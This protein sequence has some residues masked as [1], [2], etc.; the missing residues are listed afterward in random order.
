MD[1][2]Q[3]RAVK[4]IY[5]FHYKGTQYEDVPIL[6][7]LDDLEAR[8]IRHHLSVMYRQSR[9]YSNIHTF[10]PSVDLRSQ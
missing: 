1:R 2:I 5:R 7:G 4:N 9:N 8:R 6:Y 3:K 10:R